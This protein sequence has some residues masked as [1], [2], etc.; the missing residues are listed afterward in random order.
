MREGAITSYGRPVLSHMVTALLT[1][2]LVAIFFGD[3]LGFRR[4]PPLAQI[5]GRARSQAPPLPS[6]LLRPDPVAPRGMF[7][8]RLLRFPKTC[9]RTSIP[10]SG[11]TFGSITRPTRASS[12]SR[13]RPRCPVSSA[14]TPRPEPGRASSSTSKAIS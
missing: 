6:R 5:P 1:L 13:P 2:T 9:S 12:T 3:R 8:T 10:T 4:P 7:R 14:T 11:T